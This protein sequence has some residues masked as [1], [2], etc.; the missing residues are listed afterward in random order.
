M[1]QNPLAIDNVY[2]I[3]PIFSNSEYE[4]DTKAKIGFYQKTADVLNSG[5]KELHGQ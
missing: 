2:Q 4:G 5:I 1:R 3:I